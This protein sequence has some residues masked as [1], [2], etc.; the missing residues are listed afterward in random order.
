MA[1]KKVA[2]EGLEVHIN[3]NSAKVT[4]VIPTGSPGGSRSTYPAIREEVEGA[5]GTLTAAHSGVKFFPAFLTIQ[6]SPNGPYE[7][8][9]WLD[10][11]RGTNGSVIEQPIGV[12]ITERFEVLFP[13]F[14]EDMQAA[15]ASLAS[16]DTYRMWRLLL[17]LRQL[18]ASGRVDY[19]EAM[20]RPIVIPTMLGEAIKRSCLDMN[21]DSVRL[22]FRPYGKMTG[23]DEALLQEL[24]ASLITGDSF[25][26]VMTEAATGGTM[27][28]ADALF[29]PIPAI[30]GD[31]CIACLSLITSYDATKGLQIGIQLDPV[32]LDSGA[33]QLFGLA[34]DIS[35]DDLLSL[36]YAGLIT[37]G[38]KSED[39]V[40][41]KGVVTSDL[42]KAGDLALTGAA[43]LLR[44]TAPLT[45][46]SINAKAIEA[47]ANGGEFEFRCKKE[48]R[49]WADFDSSTSQALD[50]LRYV[51]GS[52]YSAFSKRG[53]DA[54][55]PV[56]RLLQKAASL[57][58]IEV[59]QVRD[60]LLPARTTSISR[61]L[62]ALAERQA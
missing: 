11:F 48:P 20:L 12:Y 42:S 18:A 44:A 19:I 16:N 17:G 10:M 35:D 1:D 28:L 33:V 41:V 31:A 22:R 7:N 32:A 58:D 9:S 57:G 53:Y 2:P 37:V 25:T 54:T 60:A 62:S 27:S 3:I 55:K 59:S 23:S 49:P 39:S 14:R 21:A 5:A 51:G 26:Q 38:R 40:T 30:T 45:Y 4:L 47:M 13:K 24:A 8:T 34:K 43:L 56:D 52:G 6:T 29:A 61:V 36:A 50:G 15:F 46:D